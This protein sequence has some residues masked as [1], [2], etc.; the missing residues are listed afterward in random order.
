MSYPTIFTTPGLKAFAEAI[1]TERQD[2]LAKWGDQHHPDG[3]GLTLDQLAWA[4]EARER[5]QQA[6]KDGTLT[7]AH[8]LEEEVAEAMAEA[9]PARLREELLQVAAVCAAWVHDLDTRETCPKCST[10]YE[11]LGHHKTKSGNG[12][13]RKCA[14]EYERLRRSANKDVINARRRELYDSDRRREQLLRYK[15]GLSVEEERAMREAQNN[16]CAIC[17]AETDLHVD[18]HH[19]KGHVRGLLCASCNNGLGRFRDNP[20]FLLKAA[21]YVKATADA[22][23]LADLDSREG[24]R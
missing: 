4:E 22:A 14:T 20:D 13:C 23:W 2:Q 21:D 3:T 10:S 6:A 11:A 16:A 19:G 9:D 18:H 15:Y 24:V 5:C 1:D 8:I 17:G 7:W 12:W